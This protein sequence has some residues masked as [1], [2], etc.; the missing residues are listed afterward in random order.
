MKNFKS[1]HVITSGFLLPTFLPLH[2]ILATKI[3]YSFY[4]P[5]LPKKILELGIF[6]LFFWGVGVFL[7]RS[8]TCPTAALLQ[9]PVERAVFRG[10]LTTGSAQRSAAIADFSILPEGVRRAAGHVFT[11]SCL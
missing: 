1:L 9:L 7:Q 4:F 3:I 11:C 5:F 10:S 6:W 8:R 2:S